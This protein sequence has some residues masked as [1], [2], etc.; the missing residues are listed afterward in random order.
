MLRIRIGNTQSL[1]ITVQQLRSLSTLKPLLSIDKSITWPKTSSPRT[2]SYF[3][4]KNP[5]P[6]Q[7][8]LHGNVENRNRLETRCLD[9]RA[10][11]KTRSRAVSPIA[12]TFIRHRRYT[13]SGWMV[14]RLDISGGRRRCPTN[15]ENFQHDGSFEKSRAN[16]KRRRKRGGTQARWRRGPRKTR[17]FFF[18]HPHSTCQIDSRF[19]GFY[20]KNIALG[21][22]RPN[23]IIEA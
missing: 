4:N 6:K 15:N 16:R 13:R 18:F 20:E 1:S 21:I 8:M 19:I 12:A 14:E 2:F 5:S 3:E 17:H 22:I 23:F 11:D 7:A 9:K 10:A